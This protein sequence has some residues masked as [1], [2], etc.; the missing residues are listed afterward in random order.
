MRYIDKSN[1]LVAFDNYILEVQPK[2]W[3]KVSDSKKLDLQNHLYEEQ[4]GLCCYCEEQLKPKGFTDNKNLT[5][6][7]HIDH[8]RAKGNPIYTHLTFEQRN[9]VLSCMGYPLNDTPPP[10]VFDEK[11]RI[12]R[13]ET[14]GVTSCFCGK[15]KDEHPFDEKNFLFPTEFL[16]LHTY[17]IYDEGKIK[18][19]DGVDI[20]KA[21]YTIDLL[22]LNCNY[23]VEQRN[24]ELMSFVDY[25]DD[26]IKQYLDRSVKIYNRFYSMLRYQ[27][28]YLFAD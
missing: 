14:Q 25:E 2:S 26:I 17:F 9:L 16:D 1:P 7:T 27:F 21:Q 18:P 22:N 19:N 23:L 6:P 20:K 12:K 3:S 28:S 15:Y 8:I 13:S 5:H 11:N 4:N 10:F 24:I